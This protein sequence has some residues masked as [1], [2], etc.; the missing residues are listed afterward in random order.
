MNFGE[1]IEA[2]KQDKA[3]TRRGWHGKGMCLE[4]QKPDAD[5]YMTVPYIYMV[6][7]PQEGKAVQTMTRVPWLASQTDVLA[8]DWEIF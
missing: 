4:L 3:V 2:L 8:E 6:V 7:P 1:A 5:S